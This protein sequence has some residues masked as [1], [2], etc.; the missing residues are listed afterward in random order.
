MDNF[1]C[2]SA[3]LSSE[4]ITEQE[5]IFN[6]AVPNPLA[7]RYSITVICF[8]VVVLGIPWNLL[9]LIN[10]VK[11]KLHT[12]LPTILL[13]INL[14]VINI[15]QCVLVIPLNIVT[16]ITG[17]FS[18]GNSDATRC[19]VCQMGV[20]FV[21]FCFAALTNFALMS[22]D[23]LIYIKIAA[24]YHNK[25]TTTR[26]TIAMI[27]TWMLSIAITFPTLFGFG[28]LQFSTAT[29]ICTINFSGQTPLAKNV[30]YV[31][32][33]GV[34]TLIPLV[35]LIVANTWVMCIA[36][37]YLMKRYRRGVKLEN[38][39]NKSDYSAAQINLIK[40]YI[41]VFV[42]YTITWLPIVIRLI[43]GIAGGDRYS[44]AVQVTGILAYLALL[45]QVVI[46]PTLQAFLIRSVRESICIFAKKVTKTKLSKS[47]STVQK[48]AT[49]ATSSPANT[50]T[51]SACKVE[52]NDTNPGK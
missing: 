12:K 19:K 21:T 18:F 40:V 33:L 36:Q 20:F 27:G 11:K 42:T 2:F 25:V 38:K 26:I 39:N 28:E 30:Y 17:E 16:G 32:F 31:A 24:N 46:H 3:N 37:K 8:I 7:A 49:V 13:L 41:A 9:I 1:S 48:A 22:V 5:W 15:L 51:T 34:L 47:V 14:A 52:E 43:L 29:G 23:R 50:L 10:V 45:S 35:T 6:P 4:D 44:T